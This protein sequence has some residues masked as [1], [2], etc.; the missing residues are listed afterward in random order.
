[1]TGKNEDNLCGK[2]DSCLPAGRLR[3]LRPL[4][5]TDGF[6]GLPTMTLLGT[7][8]EKD[9]FNFLWNA[10]AILIKVPTLYLS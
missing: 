8:E 9:I 2:L 7:Y 4:R 3:G 5:M 1:M 6:Y 10:R